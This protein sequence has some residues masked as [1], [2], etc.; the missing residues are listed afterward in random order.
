MAHL[1]AV[2]W[3]HFPLEQCLGNDAR[4]IVTKQKV[5]ICKYLQ[6]Q[7]TNEENKLE[8]FPERVTP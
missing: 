5:K 8:A 1:L 2:S 3:N 7:K 4:T 6:V